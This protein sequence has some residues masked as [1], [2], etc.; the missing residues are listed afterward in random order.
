[1]GAWNAT[2]PTWARPWWPVLF[3]SSCNWQQGRRNDFE[4]IGVWWLI[5][6]ISSGNNIKTPFNDKIWAIAPLV[7]H[8]RR[9][10]IG[11]TINLVAGGKGCIC[12]L[13]FTNI[14]LRYSFA[15]EKLLLFFSEGTSEIT[16][17]HFVNASYFPGFKRDCNLVCGVERETNEFIVWINKLVNEVKE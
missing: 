16:W 8:F 13:L 14:L 3:C 4:S 1:M 12:P 10:W 11:G 5:S 17:S 6:G 2:P 9:S 7:P 15:A